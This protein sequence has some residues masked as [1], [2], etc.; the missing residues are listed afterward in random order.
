[1]G[2]MGW[3][4]EGVDGTQKYGFFQFGY[5]VQ[6]AKAKKNDGFCFFSRTLGGLGL[7]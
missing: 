3:V 5:L 1:M 4:L 2:W 6:V 7:V